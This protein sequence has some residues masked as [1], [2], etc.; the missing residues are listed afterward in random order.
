MPIHDVSMFEEDKTKTFP[1]GVRALHW[2]I[3]DIS[4]PNAIWL[5]IKLQVFQEIM[6]IHTVCQ[7]R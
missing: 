2:M 4:V 5:V 3:F 6:T 7:H 1:N